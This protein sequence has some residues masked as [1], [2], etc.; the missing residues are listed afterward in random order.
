[1]AGRSDSRNHVTEGELFIPFSVLPAKGVASEAAVGIRLRSVEGLPDIGTTR[2][3]IGFRFGTVVS[4]NRVGKAKEI[5]V[6]TQLGLVCHD[7]AWVP[8]ASQNNGLVRVVLP[9]SLLDLASKGIS[10]KLKVVT[11]GIVGPNAFVVS[12]PLPVPVLPGHVP[13]F[14]AKD[15]QKQ[16][17]TAVLSIGRLFSAEAQALMARSLVQ[18]IVSQLRQPEA[19]SGLDDALDALKP[20]R[21]WSAAAGVPQA[22]ASVDSQGKTALRLAVEG[23]HWKYVQPLIEACCSLRSVAEDLRSPLT[24]A[25][26][27]GSGDEVLGLDV[28]LLGLS[29]DQLRLAGQVCKVLRRKDSTGR[30]DDMAPQLSSHFGAPGSSPG[31][32]GALSP[33]P[34][35]PK[36][37]SRSSFSKPVTS[38]WSP[39]FLLLVLELCQSGKARRA[40]LPPATCSALWRASLQQN[41]P[42]LAKKLAI[43]IGLS[44]NL[45]G[46]NSRSQ[47]LDVPPYASE[48]SVLG[49]M[50]ERAV[51]DPQWL[52]VARILLH[53]GASATA[54]LH[55]QPLMSFAQDQAD[56]NQ[57]GFND[58][59][60]P[61]LRRLGQDIDPWVQ[62]SVLLEDRT[63]ECP[64]CLE[65]LWTSTPTAFVKLV[66]G[67]GQSVF[68]VICAHFFCFDCASQQYMKQQQTQASEYF[69]PT[70]RAT[71]HEV[72]PMP[73]IAVNPRLWF[74]FLDVSRSGEIGQNMA[75]QALEALLP[76]DTE[77]LHESISGG[78]A[79]WAKGPITEHEFFAKGGL[80]EW[81]RAHQHDLANAA[82]RGPAPALSS[83]LQDWFRHWDVERRGALDKGQVL[84]ALCEASKTSSLEI[85]RIQELKEGL[86]ELWAK[87]DLISGLTRQHCKEPNLAADLAALAE[88][89]AGM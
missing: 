5:S 56:K 33:P 35:P 85:K 17:A 42:S 75:V 14:S 23:G 24:A 83:D 63:A 49:L 50:L 3:V 76:I 27:R 9:P 48:D 60:E 82:K 86:S 6:K 36:E 62:P 18:R 71:A 29:K 26:E 80:L 11:T 87:Y 19:Q 74:Q 70:C 37:V 78:W 79:T 73:D 8:E 13:L 89:V 43:W 28:K 15:H 12:E 20:S 53:V 72:M 54:T 40:L 21:G 45:R 47:L 57:P 16:M 39:D 68:H 69:C 81:I 25:V 32:T 88:R 58:L 66:E 55:G 38:D 1:M 2:L 65:T 59:L 46:E 44:V 64:I 22:F 41:L 34:L 10:C 31:S 61:L 52:N 51:E 67:G 84:R 77:R 7:R 4:E 30:L